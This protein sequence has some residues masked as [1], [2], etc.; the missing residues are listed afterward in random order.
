MPM[1]KN[2][3]IEWAVSDEPIAYDIAVAAMENRVQKIIAGEA[4]ELIWFLQH[5]PIYTAGTSAQASDLLD[6]ERFPVFETGRGG[7]FT[8]HGPGQRIAYVMLDL[9]ERERD[10]RAF[11][12]ALER[13]VIDTLASFN[14]RG[15]ARDGDR[16]GVL[17]S[18]RTPSFGKRAVDRLLEDLATD[19]SGEFPP[20]PRASAFAV[21]A[22]DFYDPAETWEKRLAPLAET[23]REGIL[24]AIS[25]PV[26][27][28]FPFRGRVR[29]KRPGETIARIFGRA[30]SMRETYREKFQANRKALDALAKRLGWRL[31][32]H[33]TNAVSLA[34]AAALKKALESFGG[35]V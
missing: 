35:K 16:I 25:D 15:E 27:V 20:P 30:Q 1:R 11:V 19:Q 10:V 6:P 18:G 26:E 29:L 9:R 2:L 21:V 23:C 14:I 8:Y 4:R 31:V 17:G 33:D 7:Q 5:P 12:C 22:S 28:E 13:V 24:L 3:P 32:V 34:G